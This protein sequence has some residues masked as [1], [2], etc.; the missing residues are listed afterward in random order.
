STYAH[1]AVNSAKLIARK[2]GARI[3][4]L[5]AYIPYIPTE[6]HVPVNADIYSD[7]EE[8]LRESFQSMLDGLRAEGLDAEAIWAEG[9]VL[10]AVVHHAEA[11]NVDLVIIGR[12]GKGGCLDKLFGSVA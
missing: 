1:Y 10:K 8:S 12:T 9:P 3:H 7:V 2:T 5:H 6:I 11:L 4:L